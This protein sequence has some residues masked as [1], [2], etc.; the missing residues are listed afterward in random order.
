MIDPRKPFVSYAYS[1]PHKLAYRPLDP[2]PSLNEIWA[3]EDRSAL[4]LY[5][6]IPFCEFRCG[7]CNL[8]TIAQGAGDLATVY[9]DRL[10]AEM[11]AFGP[12]GA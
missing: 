6:H 11:N 5:A 8:F 3:D 10:I 12:V 4:F 7:F 9:L 2:A 1:Y